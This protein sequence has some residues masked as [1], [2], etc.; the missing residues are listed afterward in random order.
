ADIA[1]SVGRTGV[2]TPVAVL[3]PVP[4]GGVSVSHATLHNA[5]EI[6]RKD[7]RIG[8]WVV[9]QRAGDVIPQLVMPVIERRTGNE[10]LFQMPERCPVCW[11]ST[12]RTPGQVAVRCT[13]GLACHAQLVYKIQHFGSRRAMAIEHLGERV[14]N[15]LVARNLVRDVADLYYLQRDSLLTI[16]RF[17]TRS[18]D[19]LLKAIATSRKQ[20][21]ERLLFGLGIPEVGEI[22][23]RLLV[24][25]F[26]SLAAIAAASYEELCAI[27]SIGSEIAS[28]LRYFLAEPHNLAV[29][30]K[31]NSAGLQL[32]KP[33]SADFGP[34]AGHELV[35]TGTLTSM[36]R[37]QARQLVESLGGRTAES[38]TRRTTEVV[39]GEQ[40]GSKL[41]KARDAGIT[42]IK[43]ED[44]FS[45]VTQLQAN[46]RAKEDAK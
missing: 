3:Q 44:F 32:F 33:R 45:W 7:I 18:A 42:I 22:T 26:G 16:D 23:A 1:V 41:A 27:P 13:G 40:A 4:I 21:F 39:A 12:E 38:I 2:L 24:A 10:R 30:A 8:D 17:A 28:E 37:D 25:H 36:P 15:E 29:I 35:F 14:C 9:V 43:E 19:N 6:K 11:S 20:P 46:Q 34:L 5:A 31:L